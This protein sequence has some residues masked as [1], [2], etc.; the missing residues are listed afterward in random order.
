MLTL[1]VQVQYVGL[2]FAVWRLIFFS[3]FTREF[4]AHRTNNTVVNTV[5]N[6]LCVVGWLLQKEMNCVHEEKRT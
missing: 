1:Q 6:D 5:S 2:P 3:V 4:L